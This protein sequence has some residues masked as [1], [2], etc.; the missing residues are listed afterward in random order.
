MICDYC[1]Q[2]G[3]VASCGRCKHCGNGTPSLGYDQCKDCAAKTNT[4]QVCEM[5]L[6]KSN[7]A[8]FDND[9]H[10]KWQEKCGG[11]ADFMHD[12]NTKHPLL[13]ANNATPLSIDALIHQP[14]IISQIADDNDS[15]IVIEVSNKSWKVWRQAKSVCV[16]LDRLG[17]G[18]VL[19][20]IKT[21]GRQDRKVTLDVT[22]KNPA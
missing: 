15:T 2:F 6:T 22:V 17:Q 1:G 21:D 5:D 12:A 9:F 18:Q 8:A 7:D 20:T 10:Y 4:C 16:K 14:L 19:I 3:Y 13:D 11:C